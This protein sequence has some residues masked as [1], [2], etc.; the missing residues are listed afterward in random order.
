MFD[1]VF[2][3]AVGFALMTFVRFVVEPLLGITP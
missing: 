1:M 2:G 3:L